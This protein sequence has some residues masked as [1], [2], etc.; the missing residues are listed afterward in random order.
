VIHGPRCGNCLKENF[1]KNLFHAVRRPSA[2]RSY[3]G[4]QKNILISLALKLIIVLIIIVYRGIQRLTHG[5]RF[6]AFGGSGY[7]NRQ[8]GVRW[9]L[10]RPLCGSAPPHFAS[11]ANAPHLLIRACKTSFIFVHYVQ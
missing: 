6:A 2:R 11:P 1:N 3:K 4:G 8:L 5:I 9:A 7:T 10:E